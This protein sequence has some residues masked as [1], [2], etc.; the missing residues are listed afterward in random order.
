MAAP[1]TAGDRRKRALVIDDDASVR[2][3]LVDVVAMLG[4]EAD[5]AANG[6]Q[7]I[8]LFLRSRYDLVLTDLMMPWMTR[9]QVLDTIPQLNLRTPGIPPP[10]PPVP[11]A[12]PPLAP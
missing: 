8:A 4:Y 9:W 11:P 7:A 1:E 2:R 10:R 12:H 6:P 3:A 5:A